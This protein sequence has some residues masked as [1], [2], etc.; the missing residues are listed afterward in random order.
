MEIILSRT[1]SERRIF[2]AIDLYRSGTRKDELLLSEQEFECAYAV[3]RYLDRDDNASQNL[4]DMLKRTE[5]NE[6]FVKKAPVW[7]KMMTD[8][9]KN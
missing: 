6:E 4:L 3:R 1:L 9:P 7:C 5:N 2:P 8:N